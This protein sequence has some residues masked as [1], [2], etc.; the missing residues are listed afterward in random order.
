MTRQQPTPAEID[1][2]FAH[3]LLLG[4]IGG[5]DKFPSQKTSPTEKEARQALARV[6]RGGDVPPLIL[7]ALAD[8]IDPDGRHLRLRRIEF[9]NLTQGHPQSNSQFAIAALVHELRKKKEK[10]AVD[11]VAEKVGMTARHVA[12]IYSALRAQ[13][14]DAVRLME[15]MKKDDTNSRTA[16]MT[17]D[18]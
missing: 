10:N 9:K 18:N 14:E 5:K 7:M 8:Q 2:V 13:C 11:K 16:V 4:I 3:M 15:Q 6:L 12:R 1:Y 17:S